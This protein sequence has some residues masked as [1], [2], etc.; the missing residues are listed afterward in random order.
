MH[1]Q[2]KEKYKGQTTVGTDLEG[3]QFVWVPVDNIADY[4]RIWYTG[5]G[6]FENFS[7]IL[8]EDEKT[9]VEKIKAII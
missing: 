4:K 8:P 7:E 6:N 5:Y 3:N 2:T 1:Q 9:S